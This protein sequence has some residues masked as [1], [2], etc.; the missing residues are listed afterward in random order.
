MKLGIDFGT[1]RIVV[2]FVDSGNYPVVVFDTPDGAARDWFPPLVAIQGSR[3]L[4]GWD[5]WAVQGEP[6]WT[7]IRSIKRLLG[8]AALSSEAEIAGQII[9]LRDLL[10]G[11]SSSLRLSL[12]KHSNLPAEESEPL[13]AMLGVPANANSNQRFLTTDMFRSAGFEVLGL[14]NEPSAASIEFGHHRRQEPSAQ[15]VEH[16]LVYDLGG[17]TF[18][19]S[20][21]KL[22]G[23]EHAVVASEG[24]ESLG[25]D[26]FD[27]F[28]AELSLDVAGVAAAERDSLTQAELFHLHEECREKKEALHPNTR[29]IHVDLGK[30][31]PHWSPA[32]VS[33]SDF[34]QSCRPAI[35]ETIHAVESLMESHGLGPAPSGG[36][37]RIDTLYVTGGASDL[38]VVSRMLREVFGRLVR[39]SACTRFATAIGLAIQADSEA[40]YQLRDRFTRYFGVWREGEAGRTAVFDPLFTKGLVLPG[41]KQPPLVQVRCYSPVHNIGH[42][43]YL[44]CAQLSADARPA[45]DIITWGEILFPFDP[46]L[47]D[48]PD[49]CQTEVARTPT[50]DQQIE[51]N[52]SCDS[53]GAVVVRITNLSS[54]YHREY[55]LGRWNVLERRVVPG[56][57]PRR[58]RA[59]RS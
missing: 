52:Y 31:R 11:L 27:E 22:C 56:R 3:R 38:P 28:L 18:D 17:G 36:E 8:S 53:N 20:L 50:A 26:D 1:T 40:G 13:E 46:A 2:A 34:Y 51:E 29:F 55:R 21:V 15:R 42:F 33:T 5:A 58:R 7:V 23:R 24:I 45:G 37:A 19:A 32:T 10:K 30:V 59:P 14:L 44:E 39:R 12:L 47:R 16:I 48:V 54:G 6:G 49:L 57:S 25:G 4:F 41:P 43:R 9:P 35:Q